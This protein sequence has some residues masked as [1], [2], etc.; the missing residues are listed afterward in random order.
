MTITGS[1]IFLPAKT[2]TRL[3]SYGL[4]HSITPKRIPAETIVSS[5]KAVLAYQ[6]DLP[7]TTKDEIRSRVASTLQSSSIRDNNLTT[8]E[9]QALKRLK[10]DD[11]IV[12]LSADKGRV[13][14]HCCYG[15]DRLLRQNG[16]TG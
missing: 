7:E 1:G 4:K 12:I 2:E 15:Q 3:L 11:N 8:D 16:R 10:H 13:T 9:K 6:R 14:V 5:V